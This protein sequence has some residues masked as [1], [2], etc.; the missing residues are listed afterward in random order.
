MLSRGQHGLS[1]LLLIMSLRD[2]FGLL[3]ISGLWGVL[4]QLTVPFMITAPK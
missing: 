3:G 4:V 2:L 1:K